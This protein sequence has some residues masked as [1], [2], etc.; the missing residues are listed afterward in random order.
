[1]NLPFGLARN[2]GWP[3][4]FGLFRIQ[5][6]P[7][8]KR[9]RR[10]CDRDCSNSSKFAS[11]RSRC[12]TEISHTAFPLFEARRSTSR[13]GVPLDERSPTK[14]TAVEPI[15]L[16]AY[17][18]SD[19]VNV[20]VLSTV[21][22]GFFWTTPSLG[23]IPAEKGP[24]RATPGLACIPQRG[25]LSRRATIQLRRQ[26]VKLRA[27]RHRLPGTSSTRTSRSGNRGY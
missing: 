22:R 20:N 26:V 12:I 10:I 17:Q 8:R 3:P 2:L 15:P 21:A 5:Q 19:R 11:T 13:P 14:I 24:G 18:P 16:G 27:E 1:M 23:H 9:F 6:K 4:A 25:M 7:R